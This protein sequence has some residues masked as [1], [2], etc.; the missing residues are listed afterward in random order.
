MVWIKERIMLRMRLKYSKRRNSIYSVILF[1]LLLI[2]VNSYGQY[3]YNDVQG[4]W[5]LNYNHKSDETPQIFYNEFYVFTQNRFLI[6][7]THTSWCIRCQGNNIGLYEYGFSNSKFDIDTLLNHGQYFVYINDNDYSVLSNF[8]VRSKEY[9]ELQYDE[10]SYIERLP[11]KAQIV[12]Y[13]R[14]LHDHRNYAREFLEY[15]ICDVKTD[16]VHLL[17]SLQNKTDVVIGKDDIV[18]VRDTAGALLQV[19]YE[20]EPDKYVIGYLRRED[21]QFVYDEKE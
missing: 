4:I 1:M 20:P 10:C 3:T 17:D 13:K 19:E 7:A 21:L 8:V 18:V 2:S 12:L 15:D 6:I 11:K 16:N 5:M 14:G 9:M